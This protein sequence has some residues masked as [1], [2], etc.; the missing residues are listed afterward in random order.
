M[1]K[2]NDQQCKYLGTANPDGYGWCELIDDAVPIGW[3]LGRIVCKQKDCGNNKEEDMPSIKV[4]A[5]IWTEGQFQ[6]LK[7]RIGKSYFTLQW[8]QYIAGMTRRQ[9]ERYRSR[10][11]ESGEIES[12]SLL[13]GTRCERCY[14]FVR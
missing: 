13:S 3:K 1:A 5:E 7:K 4:K 12:C 2:Q 14:R 9:A 6:R 11:M 10:L 8:L